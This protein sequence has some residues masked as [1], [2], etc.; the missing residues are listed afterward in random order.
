MISPERP[1]I[2]E[3]RRTIEELIEEPKESERPEVIEKRSIEELI[4]EPKESERPQIIELRGTIEEL[5]EEP[6]LP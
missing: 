5:I 4:K 6:T 2:I 3:L 1:E